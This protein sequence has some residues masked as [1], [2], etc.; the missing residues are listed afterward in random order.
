MLPDDVLVELFNFYQNIDYPQWYTE[1]GQW[2]ALVHVC[3]RWRCLVFAFPRRLNL[4]L[5]YRAHRPMSE[6]LDVWPILP[7]SLRSIINE[8]RES[9]QW[10]DNTV[11]ALESE[12]S[13]RICEISIYVINSHWERFTEAMQKPF[14]ELTHL[15]V[16]TN[17]VLVLPDSFLGGSAP[18]LRSL[19]LEGIPFPSIPNLLL[20]A[21]RLVELFLWNIPHSG[22]FSPDE[23][24]TALAV[25]TRLETLD[26]RF[27]S[28]QSRPDPESR[29]LPPPTRF[30][31]P[32]LTRLIFK[33]VYEYLEDLLARIDVPHLYYLRIEFFMDLDF[34]VPQL[35]RL[36]GHAEEFKTFDRADVVIY[37]RVIQLV[38]HPNTVEFNDS[39]RL[40]LLIHCGRL[41][42][43]LS[44]LTQVCSSSCPLISALEELKIG[45]D[46]SLSSSHW[47]E[48]TK[49][50]QWLELL[51]PFTA[52][53]RLHF[54]D[55][56]AQHFSGALQASGTWEN[57]NLYKPLKFT[58]I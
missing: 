11:A 35:H 24:A 34:D 41:D 55:G 44:S 26:L 18:R 15:E 27:D 5:T 32:A 14:P 10:W 25:M 37:D 57:S 52:L 1:T 7:V 48:D 49:N 39:M 8:D 31:L 17:G 22:Y 36:I 6:L 56:I 51:D 40:Q 43:Q 12:H 23:M 2:D 38:L 21:S 13:N 16:S 3:R 20:S 58:I 33:G 50:A 46:G 29:H 28:P 47:K 4:R 54:T 30:V 45:E 9:D 19:W 42:Y 53:K